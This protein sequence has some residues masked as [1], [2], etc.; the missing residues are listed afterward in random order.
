VERALLVRALL[1]V[2]LVMALLVVWR[3]WR[4]YPGLAAG[5]AVVAAVLGALL[6]QSP[7]LPMLALAIAGGLAFLASRMRK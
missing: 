3:G 4:E 7:F 5:A 2:A 1:V 6:I